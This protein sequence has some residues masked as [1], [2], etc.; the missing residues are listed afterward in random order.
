[1]LLLLLL[2]LVGLVLLLLSYRGN[3][4][5]DLPFAV[6]VA[7]T[8]GGLCAVVAVLQGEPGA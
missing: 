2:L 6:A 8:A 4:E 1:M 5:P 3:L 7:A